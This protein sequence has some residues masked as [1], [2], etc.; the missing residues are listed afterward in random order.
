MRKAL[1]ILLLFC[2]LAHTDITGLVVGV[3]ESDTIKVLDADDTEYK[4]RMT[5]ISYRQF[6]TPYSRQGRK[7]SSG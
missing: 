5:D 6:S 7:Y 1:L 4:V 2:S 3:I